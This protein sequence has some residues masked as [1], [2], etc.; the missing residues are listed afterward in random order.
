MTDDHIL[1]VAS[2]EGSISQYLFNAD[3]GSL[4]FQNKIYT[5]AEVSFLCVSPDKKYLYATQRDDAIREI[6]S[7]KI[8]EDNREL[9]LVN[10]ATAEGARPVHLSID[11]TGRFIFQANFN[12]GNFSMFPVNADG[13]LC[14]SI[15]TFD[16]GQNPH[17]IKVDEDNKNIYVTHMGSDFIAQYLFDSE[18]GRMIPN[19]PHVINVKSKTGPRHFDFHQNGKWVYVINELNNTITLF[20]KNANGTLKEV[21]SYTTLADDFMGSSKTAD[22]HVHPN[23]RFL[24]GSNR[25]DDS[26][27]VYSIDET[28]GALQLRE[29]V[30]SQGEEPRSFAI[31]PTGKFLIVGNRSSNEIIIFEI[32]AHT[33]RI[34]RCAGSYAHSLPICLVFNN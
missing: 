22:I 4:A 17:Q 18:N 8:G 23:G 14:S 7:Y 13:S 6:A 31:D 29:I 1:Y 34:V 32:D 27:A 15:Q 9:I 26:I 25:G 30:K 11:K 3:S 10:K 21:T 20:T 5:G 19:S 28:N 12:G 33:G 2:S 24:Y 16:L